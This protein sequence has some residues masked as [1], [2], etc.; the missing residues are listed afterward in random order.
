MQV[1]EAVLSFESAN[2]SLDTAQLG[3]QSATD[4]LDLA[5]EQF[6]TGAITY[7]DVL[8]SQLAYQQAQTGLL[9]AQFDLLLAKIK[10]KYVTGM[11]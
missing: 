6:N 4:F 8:N 2:A 5:R 11:L 7:Q 1:T 9:S 3:A 10:L